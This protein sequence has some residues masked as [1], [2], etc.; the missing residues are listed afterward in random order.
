MS[1]TQALVKKEQHYRHTLTGINLA[2][3]EKGVDL[4]F[5]DKKSGRP[6]FDFE[7]YLFKALKVNINF[8]IND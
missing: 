4:S 2:L 7:H 3:E 5:L 6:L 1:C 8:E